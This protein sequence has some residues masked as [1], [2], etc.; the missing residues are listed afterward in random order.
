[1]GWPAD[2]LKGGKTRSTNHLDPQGRLLSRCDEGLSTH[3]PLRNE[4]PAPQ[5]SAASEEHSS[6]PC[7]SP[8]EVAVSSDRSVW[9]MKTRLLIPTNADS[10]WPAQ[11]RC[12]QLLGVLK[13]SSG[14]IRAQLLPLPSP[15]LLFS[16]VLTAR[17]LPNPGRPALR[18]RVGFRVRN[19]PQLP[20]VSLAVL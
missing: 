7:S 14:C 6:P 20:G 17:A 8:P 9:A 15:L 11:P 4:E 16:S 19:L 12:A 2:T 1:M 3:V 18:L 5:R 10:P 13:A